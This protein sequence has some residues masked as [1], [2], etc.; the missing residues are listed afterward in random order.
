M[1]I[2]IDILEKQVELVTSA[3]AEVLACEKLGGADAHVLSAATQQALAGVFELVL[4]LGNT[5]NA[6]RANGF[7]LNAL[8]KLAETKSNKQEVV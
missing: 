1:Q 2:E 8:L 6:Q 7:R 3:C 4:A 5:L